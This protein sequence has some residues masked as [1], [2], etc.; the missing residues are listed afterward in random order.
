[1]K[2]SPGSAPPGLRVQFLDV[3]DAG[4]RTR[5]ARGGRPVLVNVW[6]DRTEFRE[7]SR[8]QC[9]AGR[10]LR[11]ADTVVIDPGSASVQRFAE[12]FDDLFFRSG[13]GH[14]KNDRRPQKLSGSRA[15]RAGRIR[16]RVP[17]EIRKSIT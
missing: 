12:H 17:W 4:S 16:A 11:E 15:N 2:W 5:V 8:F 9:D 14:E 13:R 3:P 10:Y 7:G 6:L 1:M